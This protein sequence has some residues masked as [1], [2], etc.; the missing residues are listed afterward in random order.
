M[1]NG[2]RGKPSTGTWC[3]WSTV[4]SSSRISTSIT[5][6]RLRSPSWVRTSCGR[7]PS[8]TCKARSS[9]CASSFPSAGLRTR[10]RRRRAPGAGPGSSCARSVLSRASSSLERV[11]DLLRQLLLHDCGDFPAKVRLLVVTD[12]VHLDGDGLDPAV[13]VARDQALRSAQVVINQ[14]P[15]ASTIQSTRSSAVQS[16]EGERE[17]SD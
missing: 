13:G 5:N 17:A 15:L 10:R 14:P 12:P 9:G 3:G 11:R 1:R 2:C 16:R 6:F 4:A 7:K 8:G